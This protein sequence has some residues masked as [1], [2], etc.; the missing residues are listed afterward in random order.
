MVEGRPWQE[1]K[2]RNKAVCWFADLYN[3][4][5]VT[6]ALDDKLDKR[7]TGKH[8][9]RSPAN[10]NIRHAII[11]HISH[12]APSFCPTGQLIR[13]YQCLT[14]IHQFFYARRIIQIRV[15]FGVLLFFQRRK[16]EVEIRHFRESGPGCVGLHKG[17]TLGITAFSMCYDDCLID[18]IQVGKNI[19]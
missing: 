19:C 11:A 4:L 18:N 14:N 13:I 9:N 5:N 17:M 16:S 2:S 10:R 8:T 12:Q 7:F 6:S 1:K 15:L 3:P